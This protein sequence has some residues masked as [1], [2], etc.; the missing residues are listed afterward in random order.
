MMGLM[1]SELSF[2]NTK[3]AQD[4]VEKLEL[5]VCFLLYTLT[6]RMEEKVLGYF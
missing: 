5:L 2:G 1:A 6:S 4:T 3:A